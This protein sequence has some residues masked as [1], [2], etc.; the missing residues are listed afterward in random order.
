[1]IQVLG[2]WVLGLAF[3]AERSGFRVSDFG[4][5]VKILGFMVYSG[6]FSVQGLELRD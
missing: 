3:S 1:M 2:V 6:W 5:N 4:F